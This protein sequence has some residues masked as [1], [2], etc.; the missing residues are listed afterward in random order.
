MCVNNLQ[1]QYVANR[2]MFRF[3]LIFRKVLVNPSE[4]LAT[5][6]QLTIFTGNLICLDP[7]LSAGIAKFECENRS[8]KLRLKRIPF[9]GGC[10]RASLIESASLMRGFRSPLGGGS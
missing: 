5:S 9:N 7:Y 6:I 1:C 10:Q 8:T 3:E 2:T 4:H